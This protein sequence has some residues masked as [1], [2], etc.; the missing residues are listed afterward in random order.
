MEVIMMAQKG[1]KVILHGRGIVGGKGEGSAIVLKQ[2]FALCGIDGIDTKYGLRGEIWKGFAP[3]ELVGVSVKGRVLV[4]SYGTGSSSGGSCLFRTCKAGY[5]PAAIINNRLETIT[6]SGAIG[7]N[8]PL[9][10]G[11][12]QDPCE[13]I[14]TGDYVSVDGDRGIVEV[15]K[16]WRR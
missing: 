7:A 14:E 15:A 2:G 12:D 10:I 5:A 9:V 6:A 1:R 11:L 16:C 4:F 8:V 3:P 13:V